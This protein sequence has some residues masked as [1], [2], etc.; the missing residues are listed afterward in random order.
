MTHDKPYDL[1]L[2]DCVEVLASMPDEHFDY[3][4]F[5]PPF[6]SLYTYSDSPNDMGNVRD[7]EE[8]FEHL[9]FLVTELF[10]V[11]KTG[12]NLSFHCMNLPLLKSKER[13]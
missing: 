13:L 1:V 8:F 11:M 5:S 10:R 6:A 3:S 2:G 7:D 4:I 9:S 12:R